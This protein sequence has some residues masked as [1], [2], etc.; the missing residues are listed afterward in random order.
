MSIKTTFIAALLGVTAVAGL[1]GGASAETRWGHEH[2]RQH[3]V[4]ARASHQSREIRRDYRHGEISRGQETRLL[5]ADQRVAREDRFLAR[6][7]G[8]HISRHEQRFLN[9]QENHIGRRLP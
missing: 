1:A 6:A 3:E 5:R 8:G 4:L 2:A 9:G 7:N